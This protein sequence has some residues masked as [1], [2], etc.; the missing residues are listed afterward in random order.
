[1]LAAYSNGTDERNFVSMPSVGFEP[2]T[3]GL[4]L[5]LRLSTPLSGLWSGLSLLFTS[6]LSSLYTFRLLTGLAR[7][8]HASNDV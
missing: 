3:N 5:P 2:T 8:Y 1:M 4:C 7:D 6:L